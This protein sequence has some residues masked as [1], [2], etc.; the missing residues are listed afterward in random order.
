MKL[1]ALLAVSV[2]VFSLNVFAADGD[3][4]KFLTSMEGNWQGQGSAYNRSTGQ[5]TSYNF[6]MSDSREG[7]QE[8]WM[9]NIDK[10][11]T[12]GGG[13]RDTVTFAIAGNFLTINHDSVFGS[14]TVRSS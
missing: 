9:A 6:Q 11:S 3:Y 7:S 5:M 12:M 10:S 8:A 4:V 2:S 1:G 14:G 13:A